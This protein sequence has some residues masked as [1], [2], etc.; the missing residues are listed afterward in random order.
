MGDTYSPGG[1]MLAIDLAAQGSF[2]DPLTPKIRKIVPFNIDDRFDPMMPITRKKDDLRFLALEASRETVSVRTVDFAKD[3]PAVANVNLTMNGSAIDLHRSW[4]LR[5]VL[6][7]ETKGAAPKTKLVFS[8][9]EIAVDRGK[10]VDPEANT[11]ALSLETLVFE[12]NAAAS[13]DEPFSKTAG[14]SCTVTYTFKTNTDFPCY[15]A[16]DP[17]RPMRSSAAAKMQASQLLVGHFAGPNGHGIAF[18]DFCRRSQPIVLMPK[19][20]AFVPVTESI[21]DE[22]EFKRTVTCDP[23]SSS[24]DVGG[25]IRYKSYTRN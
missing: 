10:T 3:N 23:L 16:F 21:G 1:V 19:G 8:R 9:G 20:D 7:L 4:A 2:R 13:S 6:V 25:A 24:E 22:D 18:P 5:P 17:K 14:A 15:R 12:R 11:E